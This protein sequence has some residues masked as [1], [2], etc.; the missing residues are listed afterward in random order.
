MQILYWDQVYGNETQEA[1][2]QQIIANF[3]EAN[4]DIE[5]VLETYNTVV[6]RDIAKTTIEAGEGPDIIYYDAGPAYAGLV[7]E[8]WSAP[9]TRRGL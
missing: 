2:A 1:A 3:E 5:I 9:A 4:P 7:G 8:C 6:M